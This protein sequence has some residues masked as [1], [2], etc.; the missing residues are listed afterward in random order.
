MFEFGR[1]LRGRR[2]A[3]VAPGAFRDGFSGGDRSLYELL[4]LSLLLAEAQGADVAAGRVSARDPAAAAL[5]AAGA[6]REVARRSGDAVALR[7]AA[8]H[9]EAAAKI[10]KGPQLAAARCEQA[11]CAMLGAE[12]FGDDSLGVAAGHL[13]GLAAGSPLADILSAGLKGRRALAADDMDAGLA[14]A[15]AMDRPLTALAAVRTGDA[16]R[17]DHIDQA[18]AKADLLIG[19]GARLKDRALIDA[20]LRELAALRPT[21]DVNYAPIATAR[22]DALRGGALVLA[23]ETSGDVGLILDGVDLLT[24]A[25]ELIPPDHS[26]LDWARLHAGLALGLQSLGEATSGERAFEQA[27]TAFDRAR[28]VLVDHPALQLTAIVANN[29]AVCLAR[30]A[31]LTGDIA[32]LDAAEAALKT[33]LTEG[34]PRKDPVAWAIAQVNLARLYEARVEITGRDRGE[35]ASAA[36]ALAS[37]FDVF[38]EEGLRSLADMASGS[39]ERLRTNSLA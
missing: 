2:Q 38:A 8:A 29:R 24:G 21:L 12:L 6:W 30:C 35:L 32:V 18:S 16:A 1:D 37:A 5:R 25:V 15:Q 28:T 33:E 39:L 20:A 19:C 27:V 14:A 13:L 7:K 31:E 3:P 11:Q 34:A 26:P 22:L 10:S 9:A 17:L 36:F 4:D 23:G